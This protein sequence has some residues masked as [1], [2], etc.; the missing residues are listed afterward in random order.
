MSTYRSTKEIAALVRAEL[1]KELPIWKFSV[2]MKSFSM[3][4]SITVALMSGP[5]PVVEAT[6][7]Y[8]SFGS[9]GGSRH[10]LLP[11]EQVGY[12][13]LNECQLRTNNSN[14][15]TNGYYLTPA[16]WKAMVKAN[17]IVSQ[18]HW[19]DSDIQSDYHSCNFYYHLH[20]GK[21][22]KDYEVKL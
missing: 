8:E 13:Q 17:D 2:T 21:W 12:A 9:F 7:T 11:H 3:G 19:D 1:A 4:S 14:R 15:L 22:N 10:D 18:Y 16:A 20:I 5:V 6:H